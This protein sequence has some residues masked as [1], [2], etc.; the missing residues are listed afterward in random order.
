MDIPKPPEALLSSHGSSH[1]Q[2]NA[3]RED[4]FETIKPDEE[5]KISAPNTSCSR[6]PEFAH[7]KG[8]NR[9]AYM[10]R[11]NQH[12]VKG[13][14]IQSSRNTYPAPTLPLSSAPSNTLHGSSI[15]ASLPH[16]D[17][18]ENIEIFHTPQDLDS[19]G[20]VSAIPELFASAEPFLSTPVNAMIRHCYKHE[21]N[22]EER[23]VSQKI[24]ST[25][26]TPP[27]PEIPLRSYKRLIPNGRQIGEIFDQWG[28]TTR[29][30]HFE[31]HFEVAEWIRLLKEKADMTVDSMQKPPSSKQPR[32]LYP[33]RHISSNLT[34]FQQP[35]LDSSQSECENALKPYRCP[36]LVMRLA[37]KDDIGYMPQWKQ[38]LYKTT[39]LSSLLAIIFYWIYFILRIIYTVLAQRASN[40]VFALPWVFVVIEI[41]VTRKLKFFCCLL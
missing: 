5:V 12:Y 41:G 29:L 20:Q 22:F 19:P 13:G 4:E 33:I 34:N 23:R 32:V 39:P 6:Y 36:Y 15:V 2:N 40:Q 37:A 35:S 1:I 7:L 28:S 3:G 11:K 38:R 8:T 24:I 25:P 10:S 18:D 26:N 17:D 27:T 14:S 31:Q 9:S 21:S 16:T 30:Q